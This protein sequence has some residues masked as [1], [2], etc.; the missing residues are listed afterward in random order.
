MHLLYLRFKGLANAVQRGKGA[1]IDPVALQMLEHIASAHAAH[2]SM[3]VSDVLE[4]TQ[5]ASY[6]T[7]H[8]KLEQLKLNGFVEVEQRDGDHRSRYI[9]PSKAS[10][11]L[12]DDLGQALLKA[13]QHTK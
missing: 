5:L 13:S 3:R 9:V 2:N 7:L 6:A 4:L 11:R 12:F 10:I 1:D 8:K